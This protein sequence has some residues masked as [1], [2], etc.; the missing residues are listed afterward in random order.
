MITFSLHTLTSCLLLEGQ[1]DLLSE[2]D[3]QTPARRL[4]PDTELI[5][6]YPQA[7]ELC[8]LDAIGCFGQEVLIGSSLPT[9]DL[10]PFSSTAF[11]L[12]PFS[13][14]AFD[15]LPFP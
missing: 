2:R 5:L 4:R 1:V 9:F 7:E 6:S 3:G 12:L 10:L 15:L 14:T 11:D 13:S 8:T